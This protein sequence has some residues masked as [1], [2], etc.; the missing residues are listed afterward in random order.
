[1]KITQQDKDIATKALIDAYCVAM[2]VFQAAPDEDALTA[3]TIMCN[4]DDLR[5]YI[6]KAELVDNYSSAPDVMRDISELQQAL[7]EGE[8]IRDFT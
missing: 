4:I 2:R 1:M 6:D 7:E 5:E 8:L 3:W